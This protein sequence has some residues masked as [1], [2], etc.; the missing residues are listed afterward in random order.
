MAADIPGDNIR[1][2]SPPPS[3]RLN[4]ASLLE[5]PGR[6]SDA[7]TDTARS[8]P[9]IEERF[10]KWGPDESLKQKAAT[11]FAG[12]FAATYERMPRSV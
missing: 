10:V 2:N 7:I 8:L 3:D 6:L 9:A 5:S 1:D 12:S 4:L 11:Q